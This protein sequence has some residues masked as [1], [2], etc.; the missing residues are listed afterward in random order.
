MQ[1]SSFFVGFFHFDCEFFFICELL[2]DALDLLLVEL[3]HELY[4]LSRSFAVP[5]AFYILIK[6][7]PYF[8]AEI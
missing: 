1:Y 3:V 4:W 8:A 5:G 7:V 6:Y 2:L